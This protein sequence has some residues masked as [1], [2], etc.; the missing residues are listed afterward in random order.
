MKWYWLAILAAAAWFTAG[1]VVALLIGPVLARN[2]REPQQPARKNDWDPC[3]S[4]PLKVLGSD[5]KR[6]SR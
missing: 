6:G 2:N 3:G 5:K 1:L 4:G